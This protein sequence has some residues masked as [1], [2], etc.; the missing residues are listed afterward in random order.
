MYTSAAN[1]PRSCAA[2]V[3]QYESLQRGRCTE[4]QQQQLPRPCGSQPGWEKGP[5]AGSWNNTRP[6]R[7]NR[8]PPDLISAP[9]QASPR[10]PDCHAPVISHVTEHQSHGRDAALAPAEADLQT[11]A[12]NTITQPPPHPP[13]EQPY[14]ASGER[15]GGGGGGEEGGEVDTGNSV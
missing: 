4:P 9:R 15:R 8:E 12:G 14:A 7:D 5:A 1:V 2:G 3:N 10:D 11:L 6:A 13:A